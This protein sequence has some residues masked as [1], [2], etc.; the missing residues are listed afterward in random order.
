MVIV[1]TCLCHATSVVRAELQS[2]RLGPNSETFLVWICPVCETRYQWLVPEQK[3]AEDIA[4]MSRRFL[5]GGID[6]RKR[7]NLYQLLLEAS[8]DERKWIQFAELLYC[9]R[10]A[11]GLSIADATFKAK[12]SFRHWIRIETGQGELRDKTLEAVVRAVG[13]SIAQAYLLINPDKNWSERF[14]RRITNAKKQISKDAYVNV[15]RDKARLSEKTEQ[16]LEIALRELRK[17]LAADSIEE[18]FLFFAL[19]IHQQFWN[20]RLGGAVTI[21]EHKTEIIP[22]AK[23]IIDIIKRCE[24]SRQRNRVVG[25]LVQEART[26]LPKTLIFELVTMFIRLCFTSIM[27]MEQTQ[28]KLNEWGGQLA[29]NEDLILALFDLADTNRKPLILNLCKQ[30]YVYTKKAES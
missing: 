4:W 21:E 18:N 7:K 5:K 20:Q 11:A 14:E 17:V 24:H 15:L 25:L 2:W 6:S 19:V 12:I 28:R 29:P 10:K 9:W 8:P 30:L 3:S 26:F 13:G 22:L 23:R 16:D 27:G 1:P